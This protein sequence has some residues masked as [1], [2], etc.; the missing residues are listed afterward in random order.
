MK[1]RSKIEYPSDPALT[2]LFCF[3]FAGGGYIKK[4]ESFR[5]SMTVIP[6]HVSGGRAIHSLHFYLITVTCYV[7]KLSEI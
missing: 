5:T 4:K 3:C 1:I 2:T 6:T 7:L